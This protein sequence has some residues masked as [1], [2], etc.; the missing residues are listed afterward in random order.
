LFFLLSCLFIT[1]FVLHSF[2]L[3]HS[4]SSHSIL[5]SFC[6]FLFFFFFFFGK[7]SLSSVELWDAFRADPTA[8]DLYLPTS[9]IVFLPTGAGAATDKHICDFYKTGGYSHSRKLAVEER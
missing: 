5:L 8:E 9:H 3:I 6:F 4:L 7:M 1:L 2:T